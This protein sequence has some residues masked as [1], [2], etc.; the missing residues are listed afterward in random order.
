MRISKKT[1]QLLNAHN[2]EIKRLGYEIVNFGW[3]YG[4]DS[5][6]SKILV[7][8]ELEFFMSEIINGEIVHSYRDKK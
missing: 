6:L 7:D 5:I 1:K 2:N 3:S 8:G 4:S